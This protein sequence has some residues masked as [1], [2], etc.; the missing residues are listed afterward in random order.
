MRGSFSS[1]PSSFGESDD[2]KASN[3][4]ASVAAGFRSSSVQAFSL[5]PS[6]SFRLSRPNCYRFGVVQAFN[7]TNVFA[8]ICSLT[9]LILYSSFRVSRS[10]LLTASLM[11]LGGQTGMK[12]AGAGGCPVAIFSLEASSSIRI[13]FLSQR[14]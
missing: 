6:T 7:L 8:A 13:A 14:R 4:I 5:P 1:F 9:C 11:Y 12:I 2:S 10:V 3:R